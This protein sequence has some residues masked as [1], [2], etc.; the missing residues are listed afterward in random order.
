MQFEAIILGTLV[1]LTAF[2]INRRVTKLF[3]GPMGMWKGWVTATIFRF[4]GIIFC[5][6]YLGFYNQFQN[7]PVDKLIFMVD[8]LAIVFIELLLDLYLSLLKIRKS[9]NLEQV[10]RV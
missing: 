9:A 8:L 5:A 2:Y 10:T 6:V 4:F 7:K 1:S 3:P